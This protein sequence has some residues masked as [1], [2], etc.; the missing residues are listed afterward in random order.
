MKPREKSSKVKRTRINKSAFVAKPGARS[1]TEEARRY[2]TPKEWHAGAGSAL[3][4]L[5]KLGAGGNLPEERER[6]LQ[7][8][9]C[10]RLERDRA[11]EEAPVLKAKLA[12][13]PEASK[14]SKQEQRDRD[15]AK[16]QREF[17]AHLCKNR[18]GPNPVSTAV[19]A[20]AKLHKIS[21][22]TVRR[23]TVNERQRTTKE[24]N[25]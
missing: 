5:E 21:E 13:G 1:V 3:L 16:Y 20:V 8:L 11:M 14:R 18:S 9:H 23:A 15:Y 22:R 10:E 19:Q 2:F 7:A 12:K 24:I 6:E 17:L 25:P 4:A